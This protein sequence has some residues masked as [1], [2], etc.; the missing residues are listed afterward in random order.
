MKKNILVRIR[1]FPIFFR[2][3]IKK[4][5]ISRRKFQKTTKF[6]LCYFSCASYYKYLYCSLHSLKMVGFPV[7]AKIFIFC[8]KEQM[9]SDL[10]YRTI[11]E[12][13]P[14]LEIIPWEKAVGWE[15]KQ[16]KAILAAYEYASKGCNNEDYVARIDSDLFF[17]ENW[18]FSLVA[19]S[20]ANLVGDGHYIDFEYIQGGAYFCQVEYLKKIFRFLDKYSLSK[21]LDEIAIKVDDLAIFELMKKVKAKIWATFFMMYPDEYRMAKS[22]KWYQRKKFCCFHL[23]RKDKSPMINMYKKEMLDKLDQKE[24]DFFDKALNCL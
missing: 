7:S 21:F 22:L 9:F 13:Y 16:I 23:T 15:Y 12:L 8:D 3:I 20:K 11:I 14:D 17:F 5:I 2:D 19:K 24:Q 4:Y 18:I 6:R 1:Q 10:Q